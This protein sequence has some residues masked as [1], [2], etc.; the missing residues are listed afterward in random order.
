MT[1]HELPRGPRERHD[2]YEAQAQAISVVQAE[3]LRGQGLAGGAGQRTYLMGNDIGRWRRAWTRLEPTPSR[4]FQGR[5]KNED[6]RQFAG[7]G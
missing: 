1:Q 2:K 3:N 4:S 5:A 6:V 7:A